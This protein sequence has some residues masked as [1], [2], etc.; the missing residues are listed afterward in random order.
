MVHPF[1]MLTEM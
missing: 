1:Y